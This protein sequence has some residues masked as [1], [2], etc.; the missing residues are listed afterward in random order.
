[1]MLCFFSLLISG[2][3][4]INYRIGLFFLSDSRFFLIGLGIISF[5]LFDLENILI[6][7]GDFFVSLSFFLSLGSRLT[8]LILLFS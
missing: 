4:S 1:M 5:D 2:A 7:I 8:G 3:K 6:T